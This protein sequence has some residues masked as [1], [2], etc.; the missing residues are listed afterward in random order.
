MGGG[1]GGLRRAGGGRRS[2]G[3]EYTQFVHG[4]SR[5]AVRCRPLHPYNAGTEH[6]GFSQ[7]RQALLAPSAQRHEVF[8]ESHNG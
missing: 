8:G 6:V 2:V 7:T 3:G 5:I 4:R 1:G